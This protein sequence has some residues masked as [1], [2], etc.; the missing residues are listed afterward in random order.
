MRGHIGFLVFACVALGC[1]E[2]S[3]APARR[4]AP[5]DTVFTEPLVLIGEVDGAPEYLFG[6]VASV[7]AGPNGTIYVADQMG[8]TVRAYDLSGRFLGTVGS[9]GQGP[10]EFDFPNDITFDPT[11]RLYVRDLSRIT[12]FGPGT[13]EEVLDSLIRTVSMRG[14]NSPWSARA[15]TDGHLYY[16]PDYIFRDFQRRR[17][18]FQVFDSTGAT[19]DTVYAPMVRN[20]DF[21]GRGAVYPINE[22]NGLMLSG[23]NRAPFEATASWDITASGSVLTSSGDSYEI[24][25]WGPTGDTVQLIRLEREPRKV[26]E[27]ESRDSARKFQERLDSVPGPL[28]RVRGMSDVAR[29]GKLPEV[30]P[31]IL[32]LHV[33]QTGN[34]W[35]RR[36]PP[37]GDAGRTFF[38]VLN[39]SGVP[40]RTV[41]VRADLLLDP[42]PFVSTELVIGVTTDPATEVEKVAVFRVP[43]R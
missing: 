19:G 13:N 16:S 17:Y 20:M 26:P 1:G 29:S 28:E 5:P 18:F 30:L 38:D 9:E 36:W 42:P 12:V 4:A 23:L 37:S 41:I 24:V 10:G 21:L 2:G 7:A 40:L 27:S 8:S 33:D 22:R 43:N 6:N 25:E 39:G 15:K 35:L 3:D 14:F 32:A 31:E 34:I 11:G